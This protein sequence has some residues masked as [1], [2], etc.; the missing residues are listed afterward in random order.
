MHRHILGVI[1]L[2][3][4]IVTGM[5]IDDNGHDFA[6]TQLT[7]APPLERAAVEQTLIVNRLEDLAKIVDIAEHGDQ[8]AHKDSPYGLGCM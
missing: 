5:E 3:I 1:V 7:L 6:Q 4:A 2:E 8:L